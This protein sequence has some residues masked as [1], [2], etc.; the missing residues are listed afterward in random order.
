MSSAP[1]APERQFRG[2]LARTILLLFL[3]LA[4]V[5]LLFTGL[6]V[7]VWL[8]VSPVA[9]IYSQP[10]SLTIIA[11]LLYMVTLLL[12]AF[13]IWQVI[14]RRMIQPLGQLTSTMQHFVL[15]NWEERVPVEREDEIGLLT[16]SFNQMAN[17]LS[18]VYQELETQVEQRAV[19]F[20]IVTEIAQIM[21]SASQLDE[22]LRKVV[23]LLVNHF[24]YTFAAIFL[25][26]PSGQYAILQ[27]AALSP[28]MEAHGLS[29]E[30]YSGIRVRID[31]PEANS[32][33]LVG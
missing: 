21:I 14:Q 22:L 1:T 19:Q 18:G 6:M 5:P 4:L 3:P 28:D 2:R 10:N 32:I 29:A 7:A 20:Y 13:V 8:A 27:E 16:Y 24:G 26:D 11:I 30:N 31:A 12:V 33:S 25:A 15:G 17:E 23:K 9:G